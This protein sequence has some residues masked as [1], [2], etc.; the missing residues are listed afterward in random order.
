MHKNVGVALCV[1]PSTLKVGVA[2]GGHPITI[3]YNDFKKNV[4]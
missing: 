1:H 2:L 4:R 3:L